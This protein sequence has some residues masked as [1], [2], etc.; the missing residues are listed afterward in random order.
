MGDG[1]LRLFFLS[2]FYQISSLTASDWP[3]FFKIGFNRQVEEGTFVDCVRA[4]LRAADLPPNN[5]VIEMTESYFSLDD[6][7]TSSLFSDLRAL[8]VRV[9]MDDF[10]TGY[11]TLGILKNV[12]ADIVKID[13]TFVRDVHAS[14]F[15][16][17]FIRFIVALCHDVNINVCLEGVETDEE[18][19]AVSDMGIDSIQ[20]F[21]FGRPQTAE[22]F[23]RLYLCE[24]G[25]GSAQ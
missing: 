22:D 9:A 7:E 14:T 6:Q 17:T 1:D 10:G 5:L 11:S 24:D 4:A 2:V 13:R 8:G 23:E 16:A 21:L 19:A 3:R 20:G 25:E 18:Y 12:P 15:D